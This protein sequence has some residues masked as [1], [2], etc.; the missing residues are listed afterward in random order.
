[1]LQIQAFIRHVFIE[2]VP[3]T[4]HEDVAMKQKNGCSC[5]KDKFQHIMIRV[6][7]ESVT[8]KEKK[9]VNIKRIVECP[10]SQ[11]KQYFC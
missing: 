2:K 4:K 6:I 8:K 3:C 7:T 11:K 1:M 9:I 5:E 10:F